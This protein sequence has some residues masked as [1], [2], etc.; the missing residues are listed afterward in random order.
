MEK[1]PNFEDGMY[2]E[3]CHFTDLNQYYEAVL[4]KI[5]QSIGF[6]LMTGAPFTLRAI[7]DNGKIYICL[8]AI[9]AFL[10]DGS[11]IHLN[12]DEPAAL[13]QMEISVQAG[14]V[15]EIYVQ[16]DPNQTV[17]VGAPDPTT[18]RHPF[19]AQ[20]WDLVAEKKIGTTKSIPNRFKI[21]ELTETGLSDTYI[22]A[23][24]RSDGSA[25]LK[26]Q[27][28]FWLEQLEKIRQTASMLLRLGNPFK[29]IFAQMLIQ[30]LVVTKTTFEYD[31]PL[32]PP[33]AFVIYFGN[34]ANLLETFMNGYPEIFAKTPLRT[35]AHHFLAKINNEMLEDI[36]CA[37][38]LIDH[39]LAH[40]LMT[41]NDLNQA[42]PADIGGTW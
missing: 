41:L 24:L 15:Y 1:F 20:K 9:Q 14:V 35:S 11:Y 37:K 23:S 3:A 27:H 7:H 2:L 30:Q 31:L 19:V 40:L 28:Q 22:I 33:K 26:K 13:P 18:F 38:S 4:K 29:T 36:N 42:D 12:A 5:R 16:A 39:L 21:G 6:G 25:L 34:L 17:T 8:D 10:Q 32:K